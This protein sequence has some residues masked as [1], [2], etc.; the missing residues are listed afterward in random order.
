M[1]LTFV[2]RG[3]SDLKGRKHRLQGESSLS[4]ESD[5]PLANV[6]PSFRV[7]SL[8]KTTSSPF[9]FGV[10]TVKIFPVRPPLL[11]HKQPA[12]Q[13]PLEHVLPVPPAPHPWGALAS[14]LV[15]IRSEPRVMGGRGER[16]SY[17]C[18]SGR[19]GPFVPVVDRVPGLPKGGG[20]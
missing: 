1:G 4:C 10:F 2:L 9:S 20:D 12:Q 7:R 14:L 18:G 5:R 17:L 19:P 3:I 8:W 11:L 16:G 15:G 13:H 6:I